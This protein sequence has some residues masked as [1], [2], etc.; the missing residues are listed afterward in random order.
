MSAPAAVRRAAPPATEPAPAAASRAQAVLALLVVVTALLALYHATVLSMVAVWWRSATFAHGFAIAPISG[1]LVWRK[2]GE[3]ARLPVRPD[4][5]VLAALPCAGAVWLLASVANV[6]VLHQ[7]CLVLMTI[8]AAVA[9]L[10][11]PLGRALAFPLAYLLLAVPFGEVLIGPLIGF[12]TDFCVLL[13]Q[14][15]G[16]PVFRDNNYLMLPTGSWSV[17]EACS[18]LRYLIASLA[19]GAVYAYLTY[20]SWQRRL[21]FVAV[22]LLVPV[23]ANGVRAA[24]II[25]LGH[26]SDMTLA[27]G[28]DH[29]IYGWVFFGLVTWLLFRTGARWAQPPAAP[30]PAPVVPARAAP[31][32]VR[33]LAT[34]AS[35]AVALA[36]VWPGIELAATTSAPPA[37]EGGRELRLPP[38]PAPWTA[39]KMAPTDWHALHRGR[40]LRWSASYRDGARTVSLQLTWYRHQHGRDDLLAPVRRMVIP[41][42]PRWHETPA[43][44]RAIVVGQR[45]LRVQQSTEQ[46][47]ETKLLVWRWY[48]QQGVDTSSAQLL[49]LRLAWSK[50]TG[51]DDSAAEIIVAAAYDD[52]RAQAERAMTAL[53][54]AMLPAIEQQL[55]QAA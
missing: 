42:L 55:R 22:S 21:A 5:R 39:V 45:R 9:V 40:P 18:G 6:Q 12:T 33:R 7:F 23:L 54:D 35:A 3:L 16:I 10:G 24:L 41:G 29:L 28:V 30:T 50:L 52:D 11:V 26:W 47:A 20:T 27:I 37:D 51:G 31:V 17:V 32:T 8:A 2:R 4:A 43:G 48:R 19:M 44:Q 34:V 49:K 38:P 15:L 1:W 36:A 13:L 25:V 14:L 46:S 53:L